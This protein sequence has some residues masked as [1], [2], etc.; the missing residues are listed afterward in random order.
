MT[1]ADLAGTTWRFRDEVQFAAYAIGVNYVLGSDTEA[2]LFSCNGVD[3]QVMYIGTTYD[4]LKFGTAA[5]TSEDL[6]VVYAGSWIN[7]AYR[8]VTFKETLS[9][10][11]FR[12]S[13][14]NFI[15]WLKNNAVRQGQEVYKVYED[16]IQDIADAIRGKTGGS[17]PITFPAGFVSAIGNITPKPG[18]TSVSISGPSSNTTLA[19]GEKVILGQI[20]L[21]QVLKGIIITNVGPAPDRTF[22]KIPSDLSAGNHQPAV[23]YYINTGSSSVTLPANQFGMSYR[24]YNS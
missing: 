21:E 9:S 1:F 5:S 10:Y 24:Y 16:Q 11:T 6:T 3:Y 4:G 13:E 23:V 22:I 15:N 7:E 8:T 14:A 17:S 20:P 18:T 12:T 19:P 2:P